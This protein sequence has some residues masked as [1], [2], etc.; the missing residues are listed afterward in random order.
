MADK[1]SGIV[2]DNAA[3]I[4]KAFTIFPPLDDQD[5]DEDQDDAVDIELVSVRDK[6]DYFPP[7]RSL[8]FTHT[9]QLVIHDALEQ[10]GPFKTG[11]GKG[12]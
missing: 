7:E 6:P 5:G 11:D 2:T 3:N 9:L 8:C 1:V 10:A 4:V 12:V